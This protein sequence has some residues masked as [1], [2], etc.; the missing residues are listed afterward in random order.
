MTSYSTASKW[1]IPSV[2]VFGILLV[3]SSSVSATPI[4][5][6][7]E[8]LA[9]GGPTGLPTVTST[10]SGLTLT[11]TRKDGANIGIQDLNN[12]TTQVSDFGH[13]NLSNFLGSIN[14]TVLDA[15]LVLSFS[16]PIS[17]ASISFGDLGGTF[18]HDDDSPVVWTAFSG[19]N[20][21]GLNLG[22]NSVNYPSDL[23]FLDQGNGAI[24][25][26]TINAAGIQ[27]L[28]VSSGGTA[29]GTLYYDNLVVDP[30][31]P[32]PEPASMLLLGTGLAGVLAR[33]RTRRS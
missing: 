2:L 10:R 11:V 24:R 9:L 19:L 7:F 22:S 14:A 6:D 29:P 13:R 30:A 27:S 33:R 4:T 20:G 12:P 16:A 21:T 15:T 31:A 28:T 1:N 18:P 25:T 3:G 26:L 32:V 8:E 17:S 23:G 5:F